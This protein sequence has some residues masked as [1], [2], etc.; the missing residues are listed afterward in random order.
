LKVFSGIEKV[1]DEKD[2][3]L[4][5]VFLMNPWTKEAHALEMLSNGTIDSLFYRISEEAQNYMNTIPFRQLLASSTPIVMFDRRPRM[6]LGAT[7]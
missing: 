4:L 7:K 1:A 5:C 6:V 2:I 3:T